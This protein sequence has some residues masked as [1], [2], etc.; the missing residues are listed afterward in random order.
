MFGGSTLTATDIAVA[1]KL[2]HIGETEKVA[3]LSVDLV[4]DAMDEIH[5]L[6]FKYFKYHK[7][8][9]G[10]CIEQ[11]G[12]HFQIVSIFLFKM[13]LNLNDPSKNLKEMLLLYVVV[14]SDLYLNAHLT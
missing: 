10:T 8:F 3:G 4:N 12:P 5:R 9:T 14:M 13:M 1:K 7:T 11:V 2:V 6:I